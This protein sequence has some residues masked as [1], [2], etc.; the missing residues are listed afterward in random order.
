MADQDRW[1]EE[2]YTPEDDDLQRRRRRASGGYD[3]EDD[4]GYGGR[5]HRAAPLHQGPGVLAYRGGGSGRYDDRAEYGGYGGYA[6]DPSISS[7][8]RPMSRSFAEGRRRPPY[9]RGYSAGERA[10]DDSLNQ[11]RGAYRPEPP[12]QVY[13]TY[14]R[15]HDSYGAGGGYAPDPRDPYQNDRGWMDKTADEVA[16]WF[17]DREA[18]R[19]R[20]WDTASQNTHRGKGPKGYRRSDARIHERQRP[21]HRG[22]HHRRHRGAGAGGVR[23]GDAGR[24][25]R[26]ADGQAPRRGYLRGRLRSH[27]RAEQPAHQSIIVGPVG[28]RPNGNPGRCSER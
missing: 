19:R 4:A 23:G 21:P 3:R 25:R 8:G 22:S 1:R 27:P 26:L 7:G 5:P 28:R 12:R 2:H 15:D 20:R 17:G 11:P 18:Q 14:R 24:L 13:E 16:S 9:D 6:D 10:W